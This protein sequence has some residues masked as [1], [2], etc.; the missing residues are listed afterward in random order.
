MRNASCLFFSRLEALLVVR[1]N[2]TRGG[3]R[4][5]WISEVLLYLV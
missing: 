5:V 2:G 3:C 1:F 4:M